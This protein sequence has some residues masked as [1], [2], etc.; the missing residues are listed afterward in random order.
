MSE[1]DEVNIPGSH[2]DPESP[3]RPSLRNQAQNDADLMA[4]PGYQDLLLHYQKAEW[5]QCSQLIE[6]LLQKFPGKK[7]LLDFKSDIDVQL[8]LNKMSAEKSK[9]KKKQSIT[10]TVA[11]VVFILIV[12]LAAAFI[13]KQSI[14]AT[15]ANNALEIQ[16]QQEQQKITLAETIRLLENQAQTSIQSGKPDAALEIISK[17]EA[18]DPENSSLESLREEANSQLNLVELYEQALK[19]AQQ[20]NYEDALAKFDQI[21]AEDPLFRDVEHQIVWIE[22]HLEVLKLI[23]TGNQAY[24][25]K[26]WLDVIQAYESALALDSSANNPEIKD[27]MV[28]S[29]LKSIVETL[30]KDEHT[31]EELERSGSYYHK[32]ISLIP[33]DR[34]YITEREQLKQ[35]SLELLISKNY[36]MAKNILRD[37][38]HTKSS[39]AKAISFLKNASEL[40]PDEI[41][42]KTELNKAQLYYSALQYFDQ[43]KWSQAI[44]ILEDLAKFDRS[45]PNGM[46]PVL[47]YEAY[48]GRGLKLYKDGFYLDARAN[49]ESAELIAWDRPEVKI[50][51]FMV[52]INLGNTIGKLENYKDAVSYYK[53]A[54]DSIPEAVSKVES[55]TFTDNLV[56]AADLLSSNNFYEAYVV[57]SDTLQNLSFL[58]SY[59]EI[60]AFTGDTLVYIANE[61]NS[62]IQAIQLFNN[63]E[64]PLITRNQTLR[65]PTIP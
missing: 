16:Q 57:Y 10:S 41:L 26:R 50:E 29:Y 60:D 15:I 45:Y 5:G 43:A 44:P 21:K 64:F 52:Q 19:D 20:E 49:F 14:D 63:V 27:Q 42:Y 3:T 28:Y 40:K 39:I 17:I 31:I 30:S 32:A 53:Y 59:Q 18:L 35:L 24:E 23:E 62:S 54:L 65:V 1:K 8:M 34:N 58:F 36:Q 22:S 33:Q 51:L 38:N 6:G 55:E 9:S 13:V 2:T 11:F 46:G 25:G 4:D 48:V 47:L 7:I 56:K 12:L 61:Y 37:P